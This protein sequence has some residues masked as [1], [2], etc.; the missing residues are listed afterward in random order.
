MSVYVHVC[1]GVL[2]MRFW[3]SSILDVTR[4]GMIVRTCVICQL[5]SVSVEQEIS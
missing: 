4:L 3:S 2:I 1:M 5:L